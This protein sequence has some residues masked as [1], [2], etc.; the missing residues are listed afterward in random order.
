MVTG[1]LASHPPVLLSSV[2]QRQ[3]APAGTRSRHITQTFGINAGKERL[4]SSKLGG[5]GSGKFCSAWAASRAELAGGPLACL[6]FAG[7]GPRT[8]AAPQERASSVSL[9]CCCLVQI[10][11]VKSGD[12]RRQLVKHSRDWAAPAPS[13]RQEHRGSATPV[14]AWKSKSGTSVRNARGF[15]AVAACC[16]ICCMSRDARQRA[17]VSCSLIINWVNRETAA[18]HR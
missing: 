13:R 1:E 11:L 14:R 17:C 15:W 7:D 4:I 5:Y 9:T 12:L 3:Q 18:P 6:K 2:Y 8:R 16:F 10:K